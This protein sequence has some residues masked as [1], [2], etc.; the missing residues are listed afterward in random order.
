MRLH[1]KRKACLINDSCT[2][3]WLSSAQSTLYAELAVTS[4]VRAS[5]GSGWYGHVASH[6]DKVSTLA[7]SEVEPVLRHRFGQRQHEV[8]YR[9]L[10]LDWAQQFDGQIW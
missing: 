2:I 6:L 7:E 5:H 1:S 9:I 4:S 8:D 3:I 10:R